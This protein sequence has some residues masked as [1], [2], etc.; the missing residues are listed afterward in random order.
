MFVHTWR[1]C[2]L[3]SGEFK[4]SGLQVRYA[5]LPPSLRPFLRPFLCYSNIKRL[6]CLA[7]LLGR[8]AVADQHCQV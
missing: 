4:P 7:R 3:S 1:G 5:F 8:E 6:M 2:K